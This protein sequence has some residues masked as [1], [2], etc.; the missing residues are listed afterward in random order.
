M[1]QAQWLRATGTN[2]STYPPG[3]RYRGRETGITLTN[4][5]ETVSWD[6]CNATLSHLDLALP[7]EAQWEYACRAGTTTAWHTGD[8]IR[9]L[10]G[11][12][13]FADEGSQE[14]QADS[15]AFEPGLA[16]GWNTHAPAGSFLP[17]AF[18]LHD[19][20][21][22]VFERC[23]DEWCSYAVAPRPGDGERACGEHPDFRICRGGD[24]YSRANDGRSAYRASNPAHMRI[25]RF[26]LRPARMLR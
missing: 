7:T 22:N 12:A 17:N 15:R 16:D 19:M 4:P 20:H 24:Y 23:R 1:T 10:V 9:S 14:I 8:D 6:D 2:P 11:Y 26:G 18:G 21:G 3:F 5:V 25:A 13:N